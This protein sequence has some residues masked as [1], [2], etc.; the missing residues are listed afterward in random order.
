MQHEWQLLYDFKLH[1]KNI[2]CVGLKIYAFNISDT[3]QSWYFRTEVDFY[4]KLK[5]AIDKKL[6]DPENHSIP[7]PQC[8]FANEEA[9]VIVM[10][11][12]KLEGY[13][14]MNKAD[15]LDIPHVKMVLELHAK[16]HATSYHFLQNYYG[17]LNRFLKV[18]IILLCL[19]SILQST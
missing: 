6:K 14:I 1:E 13:T 4:S 10:E 8:Y 15:G 9:G 2:H 12:L 5:P 7:A 16:L 3:L 19:L 11:N 18:I 17:G